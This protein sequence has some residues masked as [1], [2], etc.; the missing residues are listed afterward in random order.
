MHKGQF[1]WMHASLKSVQ[2]ITNTS[3]YCTLALENKHLNA[4][5][6]DRRTYQRSNEI[7]MQIYREE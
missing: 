5:G 1:L 4:A 2:R 7:F 6:G 3:L